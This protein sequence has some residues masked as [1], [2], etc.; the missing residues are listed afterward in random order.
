LLAAGEVPR[1][2][3]EL[4]GDVGLACDA[5]RAAICLWPDEADSADELDVGIDAGATG[6]ARVA[7]PEPA[8][9]EAGPA[10]AGPATAEGEPA[11]AEPVTVDVI[12]A[13]GT[14]P[15]AEPIFAGVAVAAIA[16]SG[17]SSRL[18]SAVSV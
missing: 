3:A 10:T 4:P 9:A 1:A 8:G 7:E 15:V 6:A 11:I 18:F 2:D 14:G 5:G 17:A 12:T 16:F 13:A